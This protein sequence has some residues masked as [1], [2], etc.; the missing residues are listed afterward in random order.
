MENFQIQTDKI[1][2]SLNYRPKLLL[3]ACCAPCATYVVEYLKEFFDICILY[4]NPN[5][6][7]YEE[8]RKRLD[9][10]KKLSK[11]FS[12]DYM[13]I[14]WDNDKFE[15][16]IKGYEN[17]KEGGSRCEICINQRMKKTA[18]IAKEKG[19]DY[20]TTS[21]S[22][23]PLKNA[24]MINSIGKKLEEE[25][26]VKHLTSDFKKREGYKRSTILSN[27]LGFY[28]QNYCGCKYSIR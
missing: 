13:E 14:T 27:E 26:G 23:S 20:F 17:C 2:K 24:M 1:I 4:Y 5:I 6:T 25:I 11:H 9:E 28:R 15:E 21:L 22:I 10:V 16:L 7:P 19:F 8:Y 3:H 12:V 18:E